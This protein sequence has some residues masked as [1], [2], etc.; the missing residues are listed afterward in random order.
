MFLPDSSF[1]GVIMQ[2]LSTEDK[3]ISS[4]HR[5]LADEGYKVH[6]LVLTGYLKAMEDM[7]VLKAKDIPPSKVYSICTSVQR[8]VYQSVGE[9]CRNLEVADER[10]PA[11][12]LYVFQRLFKRPV[13][14]GEMQR[15]GFRTDLDEF[16]VKAQSEERLE[17]KKMLAKR[18]FKMPD[19]D[20]AYRIDRKYNEE[21]EEIVQGALL[22]QFEAGG[23][24]VETKQMKL[25]VLPQE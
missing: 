18:G 17:T 8:D 12:A 11:I 14:L 3:S 24:A 25:G 1:R 23:L 10:K 16:A 19:R 20:P 5:T 7:G 15:A 9:R 2:Q 22:E 13:F 4:L 21:Y 6:R